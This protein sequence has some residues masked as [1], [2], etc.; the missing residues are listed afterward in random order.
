MCHYIWWHCEAV[1]SEVIPRRWHQP[2]I[3]DVKY[4]E[5]E[6][7]LTRA[8]FT[9]RK[10]THT[11]QWSHPL[12]LDCGYEVDFIRFSVYHDASNNP[13]LYSSDVRKI[14]DAILAVHELTNERDR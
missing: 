7:C 9:V 6:A 11:Y 1:G 14:R 3:K 2:S 10:T 13:C 12:L 5:A 8:G 4:S